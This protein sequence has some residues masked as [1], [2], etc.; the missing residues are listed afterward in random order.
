MK[1]FL[2]GSDHILCLSSEISFLFARCF[3]CL[4]LTYFSKCRQ[5]LG[6][7]CGSLIVSKTPLRLRHHCTRSVVFLLDRATACATGL[8]LCARQSGA[9]LPTVR[10]AHLAALL[11]GRPPGV[12][13]LAYV[14]S[15]PCAANLSAGFRAPECP[16]PPPLRT[17]QTSAPVRMHWQ[18]TTSEKAKRAK[19]EKNT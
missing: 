2:I 3:H 17:L 5:E 16:M 12:N 19:E 10:A 13:L 7:C 14:S 11:S 8:G 15:S 6:L 4:L 1:V 9:V 18:R